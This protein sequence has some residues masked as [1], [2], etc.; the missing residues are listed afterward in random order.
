MKKRSRR[1]YQREIRMLK[2]ALFEE[3]FAH[4]KTQDKCDDLREGLRA[5]RALRKAEHD[6]RHRVQVDNWK[7]YDKAYASVS[8]H[9]LELFKAHPAYQKYQQWRQQRAGK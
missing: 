8:E 6:Q 2:H 3:A 9:E 1:S 7:L 4:G 5:E